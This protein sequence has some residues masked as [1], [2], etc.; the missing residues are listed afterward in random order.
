MGNKDRNFLYFNHYNE[1]DYE[2]SVHFASNESFLKKL[3]IYICTVNS[4]SA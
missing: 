3:L 1:E 4:K 2:V